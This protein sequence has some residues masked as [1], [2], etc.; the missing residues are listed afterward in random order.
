MEGSFWLVDVALV[1]VSS[2]GVLTVFG[3]SM[4]GLCW[5]LTYVLGL[6]LS[7]LDRFFWEATE[8]DVFFV[9][10][11]WVCFDVE[12]KSSLE[13]LR[14][15]VGVCNGFRMMALFWILAFFVDLFWKNVSPRTCCFCFDFLLIDSFELTDES[16]SIMISSC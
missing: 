9:L 1:G 16:A 13:D 11:D 6:C 2:D 3:S 14:V 12:A 7:E 5:T 4:R 8:S 15:C 10:F